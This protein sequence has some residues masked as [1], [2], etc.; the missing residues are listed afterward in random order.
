MKIPY[1]LNK[2][3]MQS[4]TPSMAFD[5]SDFALW[6]KAAREKLAKLLGMDNSKRSPPSLRSSL[7][8]ISPADVRSAS[9]SGVRQATVFPAICC[10]PKGWKIL[11]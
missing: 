3:L 6:Q 7:S 5:G 2:E 4:V 11:R 1:D 8:G 10:F 9:P